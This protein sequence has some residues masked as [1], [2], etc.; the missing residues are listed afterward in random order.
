M[1]SKKWHMPIETSQVLREYP[2][3]Q[4]RLGQK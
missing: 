4:E 3:I 2:E 1:M